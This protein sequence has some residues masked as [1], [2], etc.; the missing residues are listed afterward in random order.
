MANAAILIGNSRYRNLQKLDCC[1]ND[2]AAMNELLA[3]TQKYDSRTTIENVDAD[4]LK[5]QLRDAVHK[6]SAPNELF[7]YFTG[8]GHGHEGELF[9][10][11]TDFDPK[12]PNLTGL[13]TTELHAILRSANAALVV[14]VVDACQS[15]TRLIKSEDSL[16]RIPKESFQGDH[17]DRILPG[18]AEFAHGRSLEPFYGQVS[19]C[20]S[21]KAGRPCLVHGHRLACDVS[22]SPATTMPRE[23]PDRLFSPSARKPSGLK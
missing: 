8:H 6:V 9:Y 22:I 17:P 4:A 10:C 3:A 18:D 16:F 1:V 15:G 21:Q 5:Q 12:H 11:A 13:S 7:F 20:D 19:R 23:M 2:L 14:K